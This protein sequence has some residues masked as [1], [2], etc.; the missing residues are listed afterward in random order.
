[1]AKWAS[2][3][4]KIQVV[5]KALSRSPD[6]TLAQIADQHD[7]GYSTLTRWMHQVKQGTL[8][9]QLPMTSAKEQRPQD[10][11]VEQKLQAV[12]DT[13]GLNAQDKGRYCREHGVYQHQ[14]D[15]W[16]HQLMS[17]TNDNKQAQQ[18]KA[19]IKALKAQDKRL[20]QELARKEKALAEAAALIVLKKKAQ[21]LFG[22][23]EED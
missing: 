16:K 20:Q 21:A 13:E 9:D 7:I 12:I 17:K 18:Q 4:F 2:L 14:I 3:S 5:E 6:E 8:T 19:Q 1:M 15:H 11:T 22:S 10:W 23:G